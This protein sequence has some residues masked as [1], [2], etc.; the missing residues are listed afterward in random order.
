MKLRTHERNV[1][2]AS[3]LTINEIAMDPVKFM[4]KL[5][6]ST[7]AVCR[8]LNLIDLQNCCGCKTSSSSTGCMML[9]EDE[10]IEIYFNEALRNVNFEKAQK[11]VM[12]NMQPFHLSTKATA[13]LCTWLNNN[14]AF[15]SDIQQKIKDAVKVIRMY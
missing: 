7:Y 5:F 1:V 3:K 4:E 6:I 13:E 15:Q 11:R 12:D 10:K 8:E 14:P 9:Q 2:L